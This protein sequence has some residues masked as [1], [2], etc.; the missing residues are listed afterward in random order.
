MEV[1]T[2]VGAKGVSVVSRL[3]QKSTVS[4]QECEPDG[5][6]LRRVEFSF[7]RPHLGVP[8]IGDPNIVT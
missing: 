6:G 7:V 4:A 5:S 8:K 1:G 2:E 3:E